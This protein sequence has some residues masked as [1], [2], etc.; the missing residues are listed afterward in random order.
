[1]NDVL[2][3]S[4]LLRR[5]SVWMLGTFAGLA[6]V[7]ATVGIYGLTSYSVSRRTHEIGLRMALGASQD[8]ILRLVVWRGVLTAVAGVA[9]GLPAAIFMSRFLR[10]MLFGVG[11]M[12]PATFVV[13]PIVLVCASALACYIP[14]R[15]AMRI[16][17][18]NALRYE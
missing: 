13:V 12:D 2:S 8:K 18:I 10:A 9:V 6:L 1:M 11:A 17:P 5:L 15:R 4:L 14:A 16:D 7:L 3:D